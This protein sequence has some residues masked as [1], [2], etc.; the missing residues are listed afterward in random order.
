MTRHVAPL[1]TA[2]RVVQP[3]GTQP[4][5]AHMS[6][7]LG[8]KWNAIAE[9]AAT[10]A[11]L[12]GIGVTALANADRTKRA[13]Y[14]QAFFALSGGLE[15]SAKLAMIVHAFVSDTP[16]P[17]W[18][19]LKDLGH[20]VLALVGELETISIELGQPPFGALDPIQME[21]LQILDNFSQRLDR[22]YNFD[23]LID[24]QRPDRTSPP[25]DWFNKVTVP[26]LAKHRPADLDGA[27]GGSELDELTVH[28][29]IQHSR[30]WERMYL[31]G[32][33]RSIAEIMD[34]LSSRAMGEDSRVPYL[35]DFYKIYLNDDTY[36]KT[37]KTWSIY[38]L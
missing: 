1:E 31:L 10:S 12:I 13:N 15:R 29:W 7:F 21:M 33:A 30:P 27:F 5:G 35:T 6:E 23:L 3:R 26:V 19:A 14:W 11:E 16:T 9:E 8:T 37:R 2:S 34:E 25:V 17:T 18:K 38:K 32:M 20:G 22:Y 28:A 36:F 24:A 4:T